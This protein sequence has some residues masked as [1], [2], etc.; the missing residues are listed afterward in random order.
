[1]HLLFLVST[2]FTL[3]MLVDAIEKGIAARWGWVIIIPFG[4]FAY[5]FAVKVHDFAP[6]AGPTHLAGGAPSFLRLFQ[7]APPSV[8]DLAALAPDPEV[9]ETLYRFGALV[10]LADQDA[11]E[12][13]R[14]WLERLAAA[15]E[16]GGEQKAVLEAD[17]FSAEDDD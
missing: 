16:I 3:W 1:M 13:E 15:F 6:G 17:I 8:E 5:F 7:P 14:A 4:E 9:R 10:V 2:A 12:L 11:S